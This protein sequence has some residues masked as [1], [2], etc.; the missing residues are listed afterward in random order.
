MYPEVDFQ[1]HINQ[2]MYPITLTPRALLSA[3][4]FP[5]SAFY[6]FRAFYIVKKN[7]TDKKR[8]RPK[9]ASPFPSEN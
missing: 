3:K 1:V 7:A 5:L 4:Y 8:E 9:T 2:L 6:F